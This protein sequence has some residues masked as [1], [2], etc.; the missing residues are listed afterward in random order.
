MLDKFVLF[1]LVF[2]NGVGSAAVVPKDTL[3]D[4]PPFP[5]LELKKDSKCLLFF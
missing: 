1:G 3:K 2:I 5:Y 4:V